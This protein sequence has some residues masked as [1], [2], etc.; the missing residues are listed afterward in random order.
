MQLWGLSVRL[1]LDRR[2]LQLHHTHRHLHVQQW[3]GVQWPRLLRV[4][5]LRVHPARLLRRH[6]REVPHLSGRLHHQKVRES[7]RLGQVIAHWGLAESWDRSYPTGEPAESW[8][9]SYPILGLAAL[10]AGALTICSP[11]GLGLL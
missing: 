2:L 8:E 6:L 4:W 5:P 1:R 3:A 9:G 7:R 11:V 10:V